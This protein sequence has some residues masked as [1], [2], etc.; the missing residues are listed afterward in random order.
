M[1]IFA[2][3]GKLFFS[4]KMIN[5]ELS[6]SLIIYRRIEKVIKRQGG[7][8]DKERKKKILAEVS[9]KGEGGGC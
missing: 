1:Q 9:G 8:Y 4:Y 7:L 3:V 2:L 6:K 5:Y